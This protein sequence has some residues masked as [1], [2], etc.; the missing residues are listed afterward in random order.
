MLYLFYAAVVLG[1]LFVAASAFVRA[2]PARVAASVI[3]LAPIFLGAAGLTLVTFGRVPFGLTLL[4]IAFGIIMR[5]R[6]SR[7]RPATGKRSFVRS[8]ALD[9]ELDHETGAMNGVVLAGRF[10]GK[11]I[12]TLT[13]S[14][15]LELRAELQS[16]AESLQLLEAYLDRE[17]AGWRDSADADIGAGLGGT[18]S[19]GAMTEQ[20]AYQILGLE[21]GATAA[22]VR[23]AHRRLMQRVHPD[24]GGSPFLAARINAAKDFLLARHV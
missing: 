2:S 8:A 20:E 14:E 12:K 9:M 1:L 24:V 17:H 3:R 15:L 19:S 10:E 21:A 4:A 16:D 23:Q 22:E 5:G 6:S 7:Q 18:P 13:H 11:E